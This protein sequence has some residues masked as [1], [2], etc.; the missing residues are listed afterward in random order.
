MRFV[1]I[2]FCAA[3]LASCAAIAQSR[4]GDMIVTVPFDFSVAGNDLPS[5][6]YIITSQGDTI[7]ISSPRVQGL[8]VATH[9]ATRAK[10][11]GSKLVFHRYGGTYFLS[12]IWLNGNNDG[13]ELFRS[14][15]ERDMRFRRTEMQLAVVRPVR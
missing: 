13:K 9:A 11:D 12:A 6:R 1:R 7:E 8:F 3:L 4:P 2:A 10:P 14:R 15:A 5:G